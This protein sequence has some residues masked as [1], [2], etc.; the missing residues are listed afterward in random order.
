MLTC[1]LLR[2]LESGT[3]G[4]YT[5]TPEA[6]TVDAITSIKINFPDTGFMGIEQPVTDGITLVG[7][8]GA[9][10]MVVKTDYAAGSDATLHFASAAGE[11]P[12]TITAPGTYTLTIPAGAFKEF[13]SNPAKTNDLITAEFVIKGAEPN[14]LTN[15][16]LTPEAGKVD[17]IT[18]IKINFPDTG[19][20][21]ID[22]P[23]TE[24]IT[25][26]GNTGAD[27]VVVKTDYTMGSDATL[28]FAG[29]AGEDPVTITN[30]G[31]YTLTIP[32]GSF[33]EFYAAD[34]KNA[35]ITAK[36]IIEKPEGN[37]LETY[38]LDPADG[39]VESISTVTIT[40]EN[41]DNGLNYPAKN[42]LISLKY[43][44]ADNTET[45]YPVASLTMTAPYKSAKIRFG[46]DTSHP[47]DFTA[48]GT[49]TLT[50]KQGAFSEYGNGANLSPEITAVYTIKGSSDTNVLDTYITEPVQGH[51]VGEMKQFSITFPESGEGLDWPIDVTGVT[52]TR[53]GDDKIYY[54]ANV[55]LSKLK[56]AIITF[57]E[58]DA[59][60][61]G[62]TTF[63]T[64]GRYTVTIPA[65]VFA[66]YENK[67]VRNKTIEVSFGI[68]DSLNFNYTLEPSADKAYSSLPQISVSAAGAINSIALVTDAPKAT[69]TH[70]E[71]VISLDAKQQNETQITYSLPAGTEA[72][73]GDWTLNI[74][75]GSLS[76]INTNGNTILNPDAITAVYTVKEPQQFAFTTAPASGETVPMLTNFTVTFDPRPKKLA[77][78]EEAGTPE[79]TDAKGNS[80]TLKYGIASPAVIFAPTN[81]AL[82]EAGSYTVTIPA[83][84][85]VTTDA[86]G[87]EANV[88]EIKV[89][90]T[91]TSAQAGNYVSGFM[92]LNKG[93]FGHDNASLNHVDADGTVNT[94]VFSTVNPSK[95]LGV[96]G[97]YLAQFGNR[98]YAV[99]K[100]SGDNIAG[101]HGS[102]LTAFDKST[103]SYAGALP[104]LEPTLQAHAFVGG[105]DH[106]G[107]LSTSDGIYVID[108]DLMSV[109]EE[110]PIVKNIKLNAG[111][112][113]RYRS[114]V[115]AVAKNWNLIE[116]NPEDNSVE[117]HDLETPLAA[118][119]VSADGSLW[120]ATTDADKPFV[121]FDTDTYA[122]SAIKINAPEDAKTLLASPWTTW[123]GATLA[124]DLMENVV[125]YTTKEG[126]TQIAR[127]NLDNG[128]F[129]PD[130]ITLPK[131]GDEQLAIYG[132]GVNVDP[133][134]GD[135]VLTVTEAG[136][137]THYRVNR[138]LRADRTTGEILSEKTVAL[139][140][141][142]W[143]P[144]FTAWCG[145]QAPSVEV[146]D[147]TVGEDG[148][149]TLDLNA[150][151]SLPMGNKAQVGY[152]AVSADL[153]SLLVE[154]DEYGVY[155]LTLRGE[156]PVSLTLTADYYGMADS[157]TITVSKKTN[158]ISAVEA[159]EQPA[160]VYNA[161]G[162]IV[163]R[164]ATAEQ[165]RALA[166]G[167]YIVKGKKLIV[168]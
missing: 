55:V 64:P 32:A 154:E 106:T 5:L 75:A 139:P 79:I 6:G 157:K 97:Q 129:R 164:N 113:I 50:M 39:E 18:S 27:Y 74:P 91:L 31:T 88:P 62:Y 7:D 124:A 161:A 152:T 78:D 140:D 153:N 19:I 29:A 80:F 9:S 89:T 54:G 135:I 8:N 162:I 66:L 138:A 146:S 51:T 25:L 166:P 70:G 130:F 102:T 76:G 13:F 148:K 127:L 105:N 35:L 163:L 137:G 72:D 110:L 98:W 141:Y 118:P 73:Y 101:I 158:S 81:T 59:Q 44:A 61:D 168:K 150:L 131:N 37:P 160:D 142:Y 69:F 120:F 149:Y 42:D 93:W 43:K 151:T 56:T 122:V 46:S 108:L 167:L 84:Y 71:T 96:T 128:D 85:I 30:P 28:Y 65:G 104:D 41:A 165:I 145:Y 49:Y 3:I 52:V 111:E 26:T 121:K 144:G 4:T 1:P 10:Y 95:S 103:L 48:P 58:K 34:Q 114:K 83:G 86:D 47:L 77:V 53:E 92:I 24:G 143:F 22:R 132:A 115:Y 36:Y 40:F 99:C 38:S 123:R 90:F 60:S 45:E 156:E 17:E 82:T 155:H 100:Q 11:A 63:R 2:A 116:I 33:Q 126:A 133:A 134:N 12:A 68:D 94:R 21:G 16:V 112:M 136:Y 15:Y 117:Q 20:M 87:L 159:A 67:D 14:H 57:R 109:K 125:Y 107:Y 23:N 119:F 147:I